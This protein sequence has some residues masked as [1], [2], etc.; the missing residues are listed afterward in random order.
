MSKSKG[1]PSMFGIIFAISITF[2]LPLIALVI[3]IRRH[4]LMPFLFG[5]ITFVVSQ[6]LLRIP[7]LNY[8]SGNSVQFSMFQAM[9]PLLFAIGIAFSAGIF[10][11]IGRFLVMRYLMKSREWQS[12]F[13]FGVGHGGIEAIIFVGLQAI[14]LLFAT[15]ASSY[16][17][18]FFGGGIERFF[19]MIL[20]IGLSIIVLQAV[21]GRSFK[22]VLGAIAIHGIVNSFAMI[23]PLYIG[24][25]IGL[26]IVQCI[27]ALV[28]ILVFCYSVKLKKLE[29]F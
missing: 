8:L 27:I 26:I 7:L 14:T 18:Q 11:E 25:K 20:H 23:I 19:V 5:V 21:K 2:G 1:D 12:G 28:A 16:S 15:S 4:Q 6:L 9:W 13:F 22:Y 17:L 24:G 10:E 3:A 29:Q